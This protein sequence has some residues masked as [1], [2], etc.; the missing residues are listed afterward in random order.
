LASKAP[1]LYWHLKNKQELLDVMAAQ[2]YADADR[3]PP[4][5]LGEW[6]CARALW[7]SIEAGLDEG[8]AS[9]AVFTVYSYVVGFTIEEQA[10][11]PRPG[12]LDERYRGAP[13]GAVFADVDARFGD[14]LSMVLSGAR[15]W[16]GLE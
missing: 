5:A 9:Q 12:E 1:A 13:G 7:R 4:E 11:Y 8:R 3:E 6:Y 16:L 2:M 14:G 15:R 10:V